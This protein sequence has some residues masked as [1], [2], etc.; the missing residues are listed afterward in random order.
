M[1]AD[2]M[3]AQRSRLSIMCQYLCD[4]KMK[5]IIPGKLVISHELR[6]STYRQVV[7]QRLNINYVMSRKEMNRWASS[8]AYLF[9]I[10]MLN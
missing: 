1:V 6:L 10:R 2:V 5:H 9:V 8:F 4:V 3:D 7:A